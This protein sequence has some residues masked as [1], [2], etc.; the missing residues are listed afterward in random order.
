[1]QNRTIRALLPILC[2]CGVCARGVIGGRNVLAAQEPQQA[3]NQEQNEQQEQQI[4]E[5]IRSSNESIYVVASKPMPESIAAEL[6]I[7]G[8]RKLQSKRQAI[9]LELMAATEE[10]AA[11]FVRF[12]VPTWIN[13]KY[14]VGPEMMVIDERIVLKHFASP[15][16]FEAID[17]PVFAKGQISELKK[18][19]GPRRN[20]KGDDRAWG[21]L[22]ELLRV[23]GP[24]F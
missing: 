19:R 22:G 18:G 23:I 6:L 1:M 15:S 16:N 20:D 13:P 4:L 3:S 5:A 11:R 17:D 8:S 21:C 10:V 9:D 7:R 12:E 14:A 24:A 2:I